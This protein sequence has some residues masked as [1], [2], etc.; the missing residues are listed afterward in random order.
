MTERVALEALVADTNWNMVPNS[1]VGIDSTQARTRI[2]ALAGNAGKLW[3]AVRVDDA[4]WSA[5]G[6]R[7]QHSR[8]TAAL[9]S[10]SNNL[11]LVAVGTAGIGITGINSNDW[12]NCYK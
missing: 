2:L 9:A 1:A 5:V 11:W 7:A 3:R 12:L 4:L 6:R 8:Q 10:L